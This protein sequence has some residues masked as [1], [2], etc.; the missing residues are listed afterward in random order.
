MTES[1]L[2]ILLKDLER[3]G[4]IAVLLHVVRVVLEAKRSIHLDFG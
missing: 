2:D 4:I 3:I 1:E